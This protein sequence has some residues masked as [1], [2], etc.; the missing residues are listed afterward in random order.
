MRLAE[1]LLV[2][3]LA[4]A[5]RAIHCYKCQSSRPIANVSAVGTALSLLINAPSCEQFDPG[6]PDWNK[7]F[8]Q[9]CPD[10]Q[11]C[12]KVTDPTDAYNV[13]RGCFQV[14]RDGCTGGTCFCTEPLCN[15]AGRGGWS[16][17]VLLLLAA[18][19]AALVG[20]R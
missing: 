8:I 7:K 9:E 4:G 19:L 6:N 1:T 17:A 2:L 14:S 15:A 12:L 11:A 3:G 20:G 5:A 18:V 10:D 13:A 16:S